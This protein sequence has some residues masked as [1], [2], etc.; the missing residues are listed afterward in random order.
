[1]DQDAANELNARA[2][3]GQKLGMIAIE[4]VVKL[5]AA[6]G[7]KI[8]IA[9]FADDIESSDAIDHLI[10]EDFDIERRSRKRVAKVLRYMAAQLDAPPDRER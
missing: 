1:M 10:A 7:H 9:S 8:D 3:A 2:D 4:M 6:L 5:A